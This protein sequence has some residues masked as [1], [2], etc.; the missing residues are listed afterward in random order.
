MRT[1][2]HSV[3]TLLLTLVAVLALLAGC[4]AT[5][6]PLGTPSSPAPTGNA[7]VVPPSGDATPGPTTVPNATDV[8]ASASPSTSPLADAT[9][10]PSTAAAPTASPTA[11][12]SG[13]TI[14]RAYF[15]LGSFTSN[16]GLVPVLREIPATTGVAS[17]AIR[18]LIAGPNAN[19]LGARPAMYSTIPSTT[20]LL[21]LTISGGV[22]TVSL[23]KEFR[24]GSDRDV[25]LAQLVYTLT[26][27]S[28]VKTVVLNLEGATAPLTLGGRANYE[29]DAFLPGIF[30]DRP[31]WGAAAGNPAKVTGVANV[32][33]A[34]FR[35]QIKD[36]NGKVLADQQVMAS[37]GTG[38]WGDFS[39]SVGYTVSKAQWGTLRVFDLSA[40][41]GTPVDVTEYPVWLTPAG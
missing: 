3:A 19:E 28:T 12:P 6:G 27:F 30:V 33:E 32:F 10:S 38:C 7:S 24:S 36:A 17:A 20:K 37:C 15:V 40:K 39:T 2:G 35:V 1:A 31:A 16:A 11:A 34:T 23:S 29:T 8:P 14:V 26:Q 9:A 4:A 13:T 22:A 41:D 25:P 21:G 5:S 18:Q